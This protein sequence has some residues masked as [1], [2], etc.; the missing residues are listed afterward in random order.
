M[1][2]IPIRAGMAVGRYLPKI[3]KVAKYAYTGY[4][5]AKAMGQVYRGIKRT[6]TGWNRTPST[7]QRKRQKTSHTSRTG[8]RAYTRAQYAGN[9]S[10]FTQCVVKYKPKL[11]AKLYKV[12][13]RPCTVRRVDQVQLTSSLN[14]QGIRSLQPLFSGGSSGANVNIGTLYTQTSEVASDGTTINFPSASLLQS[15]NLHIQSCKQDV[16]LLNQS[17]GH[18]TIIAYDCIAKTTEGT[19]TDPSSVWTTGAPLEAGND[20]NQWYHIKNDPR[21]NKLFNMKWRVAKTTRINLSAGGV[22]KHTFVFKPNRV[23]DYQ[24]SLT[25]QMIRGITACTMLVAYGSL[26]D[27]SNAPTFA[28]N[29]SSAGIC[30]TK[31]KIAG[32]QTVQYVSRILSV[33]PKHTVYSHGLNTTATNQYQVEDEDAEVKNFATNTNYG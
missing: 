28:G 7:Q 31:V 9:D 17:P 2:M 23:I 25:Y 20:S 32:I 4:Q 26:A 33:T 12:L 18:V 6:N 1:A 3:K 16:E 13:T 30:V 15:W 11:N 14:E 8:S 5:A 24:Y 29:S 27:D 10:G 19:F 21:K 22:H